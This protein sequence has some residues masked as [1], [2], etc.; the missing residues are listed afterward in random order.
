MKDI[1]FLISA[2]ISVVCA[3]IIV[4]RKNPVYA[5]FFMLPFFLAITVIFVLLQAAFL[6]AIQMFIYGGAILVLFLFVIMLINLKPAE[7][8][9][10]FSLRPYTL[11]SIGVGML[12]GA[13]AL[14]I[15]QGVSP[16]LELAFKTPVLNVV[17]GSIESLASPLFKQELVPFELVSVLIVVAILGAVMLSK[18]QI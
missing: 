10:D 15:S 16:K 17:F 12:A 8:R 11:A 5:V 3:I 1:V 2:I 6:A 18:K 14:F 13:L 7:L 4:S 9:D